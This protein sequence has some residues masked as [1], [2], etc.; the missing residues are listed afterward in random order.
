MRKW[1][2]RI[3]DLVN[4]NRKVSIGVGAALLIVILVLIFWGGSSGADSLYHTVKAERGDLVAIVGATGTVRAQQSAA[5]NWQ[6]SGMVQ[7]VNVKVGDR[8][9]Q[10]DVL[11]SLE[12]T[13]LPQTV[14][15]AEADLASAQKA[16]EDILN[17]DT[18]RAQAQINL[19]KAQDAYQAAYD[20]RQSLNGK[21]DLKK[22]IFVNV[23]GQ[24]V[25]KVKYYRGYADE[26]TIAAADDDLALKKAK[27]DD[28]QRE[29]DRLS[30]GP[31]SPD[32]IAAQ[33]RVAAAQATLNLARVAA[34]FDGTITQASPIVGDQVF[35][36][37]PAFRIDD[38][39][40]L[41]VDVQVSEVDI[42]SVQ[43]GQPVTLTFDA[44]MGTTYH[45]EVAEVSQSG[46]VVSGAVNFTVTVHLTDP[47][48]QVKPGMTAAVNIVVNQIENQ[49][50]VPNR[51]VRLVDGKRVVYILVNGQPMRVEITLGPSSDTM[52]VVEGGELKEGDLIILNPPMALPGNGGGGPFG[53][54]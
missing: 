43:A 4:R 19:K 7:S 23:G 32:V 15:L 47:D 44:I 33:A 13:S 54:G 38:L 40:S 18:Q 49:L 20:Y 36:G 9:K 10:D 41:L 11:A 53:G 30:A 29:Y 1:I 34:P 39:S 46:E 14:I 5:L 17:S 45:G 48:E 3:K 8:V 42:N 28:A 6:T 35:A 25:P 37:T 26:K 12:K 31:N 24:S 22:V 50:L 52:S 16:L 51:A 21:V 27:L 2:E